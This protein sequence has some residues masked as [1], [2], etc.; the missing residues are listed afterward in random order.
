[1]AVL[2]ALVLF[3]GT[4]TLITILT[5]E[6]ETEHAGYE[7]PGAKE[8]GGEAAGGEAAEAEGGG[9]DEVLT[10][11][12]SA[13]PKKGESA[14]GICKGCHTVDKGGANMV[15]PNLYDVVGRKLGS[16]EG[17]DYSQALIDH[18]GEWDYVNLDD[19][20][21]HPNVHIPGTKMAMYPGMPDAEKRADVIAYLR[22]LSD[23]PKPLPEAGG[24]GGDDSA[25]AEPTEEEADKAT[26]QQEGPAE[27][28]MSEEEEPSTESAPAEEPN[29]AADEDT[30]EA[31]AEDAGSGEEPN[32]DAG[33]EPAT[34]DSADEPEE[35]T[36]PDE[37]PNADAGMESESDTQ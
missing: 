31:P 30:S 28:P 12:A 2:A 10:L 33:S 17:Y 20:I 16:H 22:T 6:H 13:D 8:E 27:E 29:A 36:A 5:T 23:D 21:E 1:M 25:A 15:G 14:A 34:T 32:E 3:F 35:T 19:M 37:E 24:E 4:R 9:D 26:T 18:G 7:V 11:L